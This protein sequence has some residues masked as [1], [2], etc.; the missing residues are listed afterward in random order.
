MQM[1]LGKYIFSELMFRKW[2]KE[3]PNHQTLFPVQQ[4]RPKSGDRCASYQLPCLKTEII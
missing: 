4:Q 1:F 3:K 2:V